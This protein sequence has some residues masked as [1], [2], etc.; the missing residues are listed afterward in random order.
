MPNA[1]P[2]QTTAIETLDRA[3]VVDAGAGTGKTWVLVSR[4]LYQL[5]QHPEWPIDSIIA[6]TFT[7]KAAREMRN[8]I[9]AAVEERAKESD[10]HSPWQAHRRRLDQI[11]VSTIHSLCARILRANAIA[12]GL[13]PRFEVLEEDESKLLVEEA[14]R[15]TMDVLASGEEHPALPLFAGL[16]VLDVKTTMTDLLGKRGTIQRLFDDLEDKETL[17]ELWETS[18]AEMLF[19]IWRQAVNTRPGPGRCPGRSCPQSTSLTLR[20]SW[21]VRSGW[22]RKAVR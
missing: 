12:A 3:L 19:Q 13:D 15:Q 17:L 5:D 16:S 22:P 10:A 4:Y 6:I 14:V 7:E 8:R 18:L 9:R 21:P 1:T 20:T 11:Q 2:Q